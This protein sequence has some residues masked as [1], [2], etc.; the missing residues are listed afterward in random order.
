METKLKTVLFEMNSIPFIRNHMLGYSFW[1]KSKL[2]YLE[3]PKP[4]LHNV[5]KDHFDFHAYDTGRPPSSCMQ[6]LF[7][8]VSTAQ[9]IGFSVYPEGNLSFSFRHEVEL[10]L[11]VLMNCSKTYHESIVNNG[12]ILLFSVAVSNQLAT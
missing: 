5:K 3:T 12:E 9:M 6:C 4:T 10:I 7:A 1:T 2:N 11:T 8:I